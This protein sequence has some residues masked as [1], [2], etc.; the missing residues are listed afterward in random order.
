MYLED[1][2]AE[3]APEGNHWMK[4]HIIMEQIR[5]YEKD[6]EIKI[7][8]LVDSEQ[9]KSSSFSTI[10]SEVRIRIWSYTQR[11]HI[12]TQ[13][14]AVSGQVPFTRSASRQ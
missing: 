2:L 12:K 10:L 8:L 7:L 13:W 1:F 3:V 4:Y 5:K 11:T 14:K 9:N 6:Y